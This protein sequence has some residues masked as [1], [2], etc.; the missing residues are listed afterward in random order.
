MEETGE[1]GLRR[2][3]REREGLNGKRQR[4]RGEKVRMEQGGERVKRRKER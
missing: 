4:G 3:R 2:E 1:D